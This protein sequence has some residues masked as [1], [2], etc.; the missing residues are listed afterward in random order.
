MVTLISRGAAI[1]EQH[2]FE[3]AVVCFSHGGV[4]TDVGRDTGQYDV[5]D[6]AQT[7]HQ[8]KVCRAEGSLAGLVDNRLVR[9]RRAIRN[10]LPARLAA[11]QYAPAGAGVADARADLARAPALIGGQVGEI[12]TV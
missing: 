12:R 5:L 2:A 3:A 9:Q 6:P 10:D 8:F 1:L 11:N 4:N 7:Q